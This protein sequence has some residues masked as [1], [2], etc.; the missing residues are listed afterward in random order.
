MESNLNDI[1]RGIIDWVHSQP[2]WVQL[3][4]AKIYG[5]TEVKN[6]LIDELLVLLKAPEGQ[7]KDT[8]VDLTPFLNIPLDEN[9]DI[10]IDS[11]GE[12]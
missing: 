10:R 6:E 3:A 4:V 9:R 1:N 2:H 8:Q 5:Q 7:P 12:V 11:I